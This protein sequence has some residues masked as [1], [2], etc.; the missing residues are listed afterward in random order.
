MVAGDWAPSEMPTQSGSKQLLIGKSDKSL[1]RYLVKN[2]NLS[3]MPFSH[4]HRVNAALQVWQHV[5]H[6]ACNSNSGSSS[7][8]STATTASPPPASY[9]T[10][11]FGTHRP[12]HLSESQPAV[13]QTR[14][15][16][17]I[18]LPC[19]HPPVTIWP[20]AQTYRKYIA[21]CTF[22]PIAHHSIK[23]SPSPHPAAH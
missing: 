9:T 19:A 22:I 4:H 23:S 6:V 2:C 5:L 17:F 12:T 15:T 14:T 20:V 3:F 21:C 10:A 1:V 8:R 16:M 7:S 13:L 11:F 18:H